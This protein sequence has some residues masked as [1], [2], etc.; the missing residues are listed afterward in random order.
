METLKKYQI[1]PGLYFLLVLL[2]YFYF[3]SSHITFGDGIGVL[4]TLENGYD[5][6]TTATSH[7]LYINSLKIFQ[8]II[9]LN[10]DV[11]KAL[12]FSLLF[13]I[14]TLIKIYRTAYLLTN[15]K[16]SSTMAFLLFG[17]S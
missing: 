5:I 10:N 12:F 4:L 13:A 8:N 17:L 3:K 1:V 11:E 16:V 9:P 14:L 6:S 7:F 15:D 2:I